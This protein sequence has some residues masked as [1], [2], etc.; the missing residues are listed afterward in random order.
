MFDVVR[1]TVYVPYRRE[2]RLARYEHYLPL[3]VRKNDI[4]LVPHG[5]VVVRKQ[6][7]D[8]LRART[9]GGHS[10]FVCACIGLRTIPYRC[11]YLISFWMRYR[12]CIP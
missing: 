12:I 6:T 10:Y 7:Y 2:A 11:I 1:C 3:A 5:T 8:T 9:R 4:F